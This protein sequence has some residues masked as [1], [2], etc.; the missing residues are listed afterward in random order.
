M[1][2]LE[3]AAALLAIMALVVYVLLR[4]IHVPTFH[5]EAAT[6]FHYIVPGDFLPFK[7]HWDANNHFLNSALAWLGYRFLGPELIWVRLPNVLA[8]LIYGYYAVRM[9]DGIPHRPL[10]W[11]GLIA[12]LTAA[13]VLE[14]FAFARGYGMSL[15]FMLGGV[16]HASQY[17]RKG[18]LRHQLALWCWMWLAV[19]A[20]LALV[21]TY[22][23]MLAVV[24]VGVFGQVNQRWRHLL[25]WVV[26]G[27]PPVLA[28]AGYGFSLKDRGLLYTGFDD[29][30]IAITVRS[31]ARHQ[32]G[33]ESELLAGILVAVATVAFL[34]LL[35]RFLLRGLEWSAIWLAG[36]LLL[37]NAVGSI[38]LNALLGMN[39]PENRV[40]LYYI[41]LFII[42]FT[43]AVDVA[44]GWNRHIRWAG[45]LLLTFPLHLAMNLNLDSSILWPRWHGSEV[46]YNEVTVLQKESPEPLMVSGEYI[47]ELGWAFYNFR[48]GAKLQPMQPL[49]VPDTLADLIVARPRDFDFATIGYRILATDEPN[50][51]SLLRRVKPVYWSLPHV[52]PLQEKRFSGDG[53]FHELMNAPVTAIPS[54]QGC[55]DLSVRIGVEGGFSEGHLVIASRDTAGNTLTYD[56]MPLH[57]LRPSWDGDTLH[58][59]R[60][61]HF[62]SGADAFN[63]YFWNMRRRHV[64]LTVDALSF[65]VPH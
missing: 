47:N 17:L 43:G 55:L 58:I 13:F 64:D 23:L 20:N 9:A 52:V 63:I 34:V 46:L 19:A 16:H 1:G 36:L 41:P 48:N 15:A 65:R 44:S 60:T 45:L 50:G 33:A 61:Y 24:A 59:R 56:F 2:I 22:L 40:G 38:L 8:F 31:L 42:T 49:P 37:G 28:A 53:E 32:L 6:F 29:G 10:R 51:V 35:T 30:F 27:W 26:A 54:R 14:F 25:A 5:D 12:L 7:A 21:N 11:A 39:F 4:A 18:D 57:W 62:P 3:R